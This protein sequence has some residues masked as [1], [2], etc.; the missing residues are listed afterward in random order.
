MKIMKH[1][2][3]LAGGFATR[4]W[5]LTEKIAKPLIP[6]AGKPLISFLIEKIPENFPITIST[7][8]IFANDFE[9]WKKSFPQRNIDVF[10]EDSASET[11]KKGAL[12]AT[13]LFLQKKNLQEDLVLLAGDN[14]FDFDF[15][16]FFVA[17]KKSGNSP[18]LAA[19]DIGSK[20][21]AKK[22]GVI[23]PQKEEK[24]Q[25]EKFEEKP[26]NPSSTLVSTGAY[27]FPK[28]YFRDIIEYS[29]LHGDDL[30]GVF[31]Y[32]LQKNTPVHFFSFQ[33]KWYDIGSFS[34]FLEANEEILQS[35]KITEK[36]VSVDNTSKIS[37]WAYIQNNVVLQNA[38]IENC[39]IQSG[40]VLRNVSF[41]NCVVG[42]NSLIEN[43]DFHQKIVRDNTFLLG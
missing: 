15:N 25:V 37:G 32:F 5:P 9:E 30:G 4:L 8:A 26:E 17:G 29:K 13:A 35:K 42:K 34:A 7:N 19:Y 18:F 39:V 10:I 3:I 38:E 16:D 40:S 31:E 36:N 21:E 22:F 43:I 14:Y 41:K 11:E 2:L 6:V 20:E 28:K 24:N 33:E 27:I 23:V 1:I 12:A